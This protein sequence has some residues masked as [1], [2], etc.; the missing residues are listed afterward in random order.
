MQ[1][2][3][4]GDPD[5]IGDYQLLARLG[6]GGMGVVY[7]GQALGGRKVAVKVIR[8]RFAD[9][10]EYRAR[11]RREVR[12]AGAVSGL[13]TAPVLDAGPDD[14]PPWLVTSYLP[15]MSLWDAVVRFGAVPAD[16]VRLLAIGLTEALVA[17]HSADVVH[18]DLK[19]GNVMLTAGG[20]RVIDFGIARPTDATAITQAGMVVGSIG[21]MSPE[22][23]SAGAIGPAS[24]VFALGSV[25][26][27]AATGREPFGTGSPAA[28]W[29]RVARAE[30]D[31]RGLEHH[32]L[33]EG[34]AACLRLR[35]EERPSAADLLAR[36]V[37]LGHGTESLQGTGWLP[38][39]LAQEVD[40]RAGEALDL[41]SPLRPVGHGDVLGHGEV[42]GHGDVRA[43]GRDAAAA[44]MGAA[45]AEPVGPNVADLDSRADPDAPDARA[46]RSA[47]PSRRLL[48]S[49][50]AGVG[51]AGLLATP[52]LV[53]L[54]RNRDPNGWGG[55]GSPSR[56][57]SPS[58]SASQTVGSSGPKSR[59]PA[60]RPSAERPPTPTGPPPKAD[61]RWKVRVTGSD[62]DSYPDLT[63]ADGM[64]LAWTD[65]HVRGVD[66]HTGRVRWKRVANDNLGGVAGGVA[67]V[68]GSE[69]SSAWQVSALR[70]TSGATRWA[71]KPSTGEYLWHGPAAT[72]AV[73]CFGGD[74]IRA[75]GVRDGRPRWTVDV[76]ADNGLAAGDGLV[77]AVGAGLVGLDARAGRR[78]WTYAVDDGLYPHV[79]YGHV[80]LCDG[81]GTLHAVRADNG[82]PA[83]QRPN[84]HSSLGLQF[85]AGM[86]YLGTIDG[87]VFALDAATGSQVWSRRLG[88]GE[89]AAFRQANALRLSGDRLYAAC[90]NQTV[91]ALDAANGLVLWTYDIDPTLSS[92]PVSTA[93]LVFVGTSGQVHALVPPTGGDRGA[94][95]AR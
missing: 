28:T 15:G 57:G 84:S 86:L 91:Y 71:Y 89:G 33:F 5:R 41:P 34:I 78:R 66:P 39:A 62:S 11:F 46:P 50:G 64:V 82:Q 76:S 59:A 77:A 95:R 30:A 49:A 60:R 20:P 51:V 45:T 31:L 53:A 56:S 93:G 1:P 21:F 75:L 19:P 26:V 67:Y 54:W 38:P 18:R 69:R 65:S 13:F 40:R 85:G 6:E 79:A 70:A 36:W 17:I 55:L 58:G 92:G 72:G 87:N 7:L 16:P 2:L 81:S 68:I 42:L 90:P 61:L 4:R 24:D 52:A 80:F 35:P 3:E 25:L 88:R 29:G 14:R 43:P 74:R 32:P 48:V 10:T 8:R 9:D 44:A 23:A 94:T 47:R 12:A 63:I 22:Q 83:W 73:V 27:Y 37:R